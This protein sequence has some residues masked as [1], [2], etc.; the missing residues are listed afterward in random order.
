VSDEFFGLAVGVQVLALLGGL[1]GAIG[2]GWYAW[3]HAPPVGGDL[4]L[5]IRAIVAIVAAI[6]GFK[7]GALV[8]AVL[9]MVVLGVGGAILA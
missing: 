8:V 6:L 4:W 9:G 1:C 3:M 2:A 7:V 5:Y